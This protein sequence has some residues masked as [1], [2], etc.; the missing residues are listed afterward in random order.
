MS[1]TQL[2]Q[3]VSNHYDLKCF[4]D[5]A[6]LTN[7]P[8][9][10]YKHFDSCH[11]TAFAN[12]D[13]LV[14]YTTHNIS[15]TL[16]HHLYQAT[17]L[18]DISNCFVLICSPHDIAQ[19]LSDIAK[20]NNTDSF[21]SLHMIFETTKSLQNNFVVPDT[22]CPI[23][24]RHIEVSPAGEI[25]PCCVYTGSV[26][27]VKNTSLSQAFNNNEVQTLR[28]EM[29]AGQKSSGCK[30]CWANEEKGLTS[31]RYY[32]L[33]MLKKDLLTVD[34]DRPSIKSLD[35]KPGNTCNFKC[36]ICNP[37]YSSLYAQE[38][39]SSK[40]IPIESFN[41]AESDPKTINEIVELL[42]GLVNI[43]MYGGEPFLIKPLLHVIKQAV[44]Q[45]YS[46]QMRLHYNSNG[47]IYPES[48][49]EYWKQFNHVD[50]Q[51]SIDNVGRRFELE[52]GGSW[53]QVESNIKKLV[54][55]GLPN[56]KINVMPAISIMNVFYLDEL[57]QWANSL[58]LEV[59]IQYVTDIPGFD[60]KN[61]TA[62]A[63]K[64]IVKK[65]QHHTWPEM[66]NIL[67]YITSIPDSDGK[68]FLKLCDHFDTLRDQNFADSHFE[69]AKAM[70]Y[71]YNKTI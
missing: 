25:R 60:L 24:W 22:L 11:Q 9:S 35:L 18:I 51:F 48:L 3:A 62:D 52:R 42:P 68:E 58:G 53:L 15:N 67:N 16:L 59:N 71:V 23:P 21:E 32:H 38:V 57:L 65:F 33:R 43:D 46:S 36:R 20:L 5:L 69:I 39:R 12:T 64:L 10:A 29:L 47:S 54:A 49:I 37:V 26:G 31:N 4:V 17:E 70:G 28:Q 44:E 19:Q 66:K 14:F 6:E 61:L 50:I 7:H 8:T 40:S 41:W 2:E 13:R 63:K 55:L 34:L 1:I 56:V 45:G 27:H 30:N